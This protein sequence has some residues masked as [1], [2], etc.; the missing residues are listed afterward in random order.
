MC[1]LHRR[2]ETVRNTHDAAESQSLG[3]TGTKLKRNTALELER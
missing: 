3:R 1:V 2:D